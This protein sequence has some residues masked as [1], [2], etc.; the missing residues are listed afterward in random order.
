M[1]VNMMKCTDMDSVLLG[2][3]K[4]F[5]SRNYEKAGYTN[6]RWKSRDYDPWSIWFWVEYENQ[7][8]ATMRIVEK[9][10]EN[11]I[12]LEVAVID[13]NRVPAARYAVLEENVADWNSVAFEPTKLGVY[14]VKKT[15]RTVAKYCFE[16]G[17]ET[18]YGLYNP[19]LPSV[20]R[21]YLEEGAVISQHYSLQ[22]YFPDFCLNGELAKFTVI[23]LKQD[24]LKMIASKL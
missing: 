10:P 23:E 3:L 1:Q 11:C 14:A 12:P 20:K 19:K 5:V 8:V 7:I 4:A 21:L 22:V 15:F 18:V 24:V 16:T 17:F 6:S 9:V 2:R 13:D